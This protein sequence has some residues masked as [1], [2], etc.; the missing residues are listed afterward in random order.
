[1][2]GP[3]IIK[4]LSRLLKN[5]FKIEFVSFMNI[6][7]NND[8][9]ITGSVVNYIFNKWGNF[10]SDIDIWL[11]VDQN[12]LIKKENI[13]RYLSIYGYNLYKADYSNTQDNSEFSRLIE[14]VEHYILFLDENNTRM[15]D[16]VFI[17]DD[18]RIILENTDFIIC[19]NY[20]KVNKNN[21]GLKLELVSLDTSSYY[22]LVNKKLNINSISNY[23]NPY[24]AKKKKMRFVKYISRG[25]ICCPIL[26]RVYLE[27]LDS[28]IFDNIRQTN[29]IGLSFK[30]IMLI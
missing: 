11:R 22:N 4:V 17:K 3:N 24:E 1:M 21:F 30:T 8:C 15:I 23:L 10:S 27:Y 14:C 16:V 25:F 26:Q 5:V 12:F 2:T 6:M 7:Y 28:F 19:K 18:T 13:K 9:I 29:G 20:L